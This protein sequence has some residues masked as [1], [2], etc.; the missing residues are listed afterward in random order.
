MS[1]VN[2]VRCSETRARCSD[3]MA[4]SATPDALTT[5]QCSRQTVMV[6]NVTT[7][8]VNRQWDAPRYTRYG[9][10]GGVVYALGT[11]SNHNEP[12]RTMYGS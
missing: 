1:G 8:A 9:K 5:E 11:N 3:T 4:T 12:T 7:G 2:H 6:V 10:R